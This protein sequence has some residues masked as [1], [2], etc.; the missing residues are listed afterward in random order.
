LP[1]AESRSAAL[2]C[3]C[4]TLFPSRA[5]RSLAPQKRVEHLNCYF[6]S[7]DG[8]DGANAPARSCCAW[9]N[10]FFQQRFYWTAGIAGGPVVKNAPYSADAITEA[11][12]TLGDGNRIA[13]RTTQKLYR[14]SDGRNAARNLPWRSELWRS[15][16]AHG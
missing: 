14:D 15:R 3:D 7:I 6:F 9:R 1:H 10:S 13:E 12:Q 2:S 16:M 11:T 4:I 5:A 8:R